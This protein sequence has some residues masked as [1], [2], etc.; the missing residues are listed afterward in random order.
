MSS[1][2]MLTHEV[3]ALRKDLQNALQRMSS[4]D[5]K[6][7]FM[8]RAIDDTNRKMDEHAKDSEP[9]REKVIKLE[10]TCDL[11]IKDKTA[12]DDSR[13]AMVNSVITKILPWVLVA[14]LGGTQLLQGGNTNEQ[15]PEYREKEELEDDNS[16]DRRSYINPS[17]PVTSDPGQ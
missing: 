16:W 5:E 14:A 17:S 4:G 13:T 9:W 2:D 15:R 7:V 1:I 6:F 11:L 12:R 3:A 10:W 8:K